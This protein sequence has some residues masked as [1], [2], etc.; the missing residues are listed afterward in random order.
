MSTIADTYRGI[1]EDFGPDARDFVSS[2][3]NFSRAQA[4]QVFYGLGSDVAVTRY[5]DPA[6]DAMQMREIRLG[7]EDGLDVSRYTDPAYGWQQMRELRW[8]L[9]DGLDVSAYADPNLD[10]DQM[11]EVRMAIKGGLEPAQVRRLATSLCDWRVMAEIRLG[12]EDGLGPRA[13]LLRDT[14][15]SPKV[16]HR[17]RRALMGPSD[18]DEA[19]S[20]VGGHFADRLMEGGLDPDTVK[21][22]VIAHSQGIEMPG[23]LG[24]ETPI[25]AER[26]Y[27]LRLLVT[28]CG[29]SELEAYRLLPPGAEPGVIREV[30]MGL[31]DGLGVKDIDTYVREE[32]TPDQMAQIRMGLAEGHDVSWYADTA[33][34]ADQMHEILN[35]LREGVDVSDWA[36]PDLSPSEMAGRRFLA[37][38]VPGRAEDAPPRSLGPRR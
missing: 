21:E 26:V 36:R 25:D 11:Y 27:E 12:L 16:A 29:G 13:E 33:F 14:S 24:R 30:R 9:K 38:D 1:S 34:T 23:L 28:Q 7:L 10:H 35:G 18:R 20:C 32:Y 17:L 5:A 19:C 6:Y 8:G 37:A 2:L 4:Q 15:L 3:G 31:A 22:L